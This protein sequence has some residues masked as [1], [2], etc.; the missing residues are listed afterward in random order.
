MAVFFFLIGLEIKR[1]LLIGELNSVK[2]AAFPFFAAVGGMIV[3]VAIYIFLN[4]NPETLQGWGIPMATDIAFSLAILNVLGKRVPLS[5]KVFLTAFAIID[6]LGAVIA[7]AVFYSSGIHWSLLVYALGLLAILF[8]MAHLR[9]YPKYIFAVFGIVIWVLF[10]KSGIH[11]TIAGVLMAFTIPISQ[12]IDVDVFSRKMSVILH[13]LKESDELKAPILSNEQIEQL[14]DLESW[15]S[16]V[17]S[18]LQ[19]LEHKLHNWVAYFII[20]IFALANAGITIGTDLHLDYWL[21]AQIAIGLFVGKTVGVSLF[22][23]L[24]EKMKLVAFPQG[25]NF[26]NIFGIAMLAG[27]GFTMSIFISNL[28]FTEPDFADSAKVGILL[29][30]FISGLV[31]YVFLFVISKKPEEEEE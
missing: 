10:L 26:K 11:P 2:K 29:G 31:G 20:P 18:P 16:M 5:L 30:S 28:A 21:I 4:K 13:G 12:R 22:S 17:Q 19:H 15:T 27:V 6:D 24:G 3:P 7:I 9:F 14:D 1:E 23:F 25:A 8:F